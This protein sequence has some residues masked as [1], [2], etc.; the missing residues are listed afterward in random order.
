VSEIVDYLSEPLYP[1]M[2][3][4]IFF[5]SLVL[6]L[7]SNVASAQYRLDFGLKV[8]ASNYLGDIGGK[9]LPRR[10]FVVDMHLA[11]TRMS[12][13][14]Y[15][16]YKVNK[17]LALSANFDWIRI[18]DRDAYT[19]Y[20]PRRARNANFR[21]DLLELGGRAELTIWYDND[22]GNKGYYNPDFKVFLFAGVAG[23]TSNPKGQIYKEGE[24]QYNGEWFELRDWKTEGQT[25]AYSKYGVAIPAGIGAYVTYNKKWRVQWDLSWRS[26]FTDYLDDIS[27]VYT[28]P[29]SD[30]PKATEYVDNQTYQGL[31]DALVADN[32]E[33]TAEDLAIENF[34][35]APDG[36][37]YASPRGDATHN[38]SYLTTQI[39]VTRVIRGRS[40]FS[41]SKYSNMRGRPGVRRSRA[42]F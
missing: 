30:D 29:N 15:V 22:I 11:S 25:E 23:Y 38:D 18:T 26:V 19:T 9:Y 20:A 3:K 7:L 41:K 2:K 8:G 35:I 17:R 21:N 40:S 36:A 13:G 34:Q 32:P 24:V 28:T 39:T 27:T 12:A 6:A 31:L 42:K 5:L 33:Y 14:A 37:T 1:K 10:D 4:I 16:R